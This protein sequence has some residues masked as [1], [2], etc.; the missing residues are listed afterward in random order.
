MSH[1]VARPA[2]AVP[3]A[4]RTAL[5]IVVGLVG[6]GY[7]AVLASHM[8][9]TTPPT[10]GFD[11]ELLLEAGRRVAVGNSPYDPALIGGAV[12]QA[13]SLFYSYPPPVAQLL[14]L[15]SGVPSA[16]VLVAWA[17]AAT[18]AF[19]A[20]GVAVA[21]RIGVAAPSR[22]ALPI[23]ATAPFV[24]PYAVAMLFGNA[25]V[26]FPALY[27]LLLIAVLRPS[28]PGAVTG[29][30]ALAVAAIAKLHPASLGLWFLVHGRPERRI[31][32]VAAVVAIAIVAASLVIGGLDPWRDYLAVVRAGMNADV[33]DPRNAGPTAQVALLL[34]V[35]AG[36]VRLIQVGVS[37]AALVVTAGAARLVRDP[38]E[39]LGWAA[40]ASLFTLPVTWYHYP[41][42]L[43]PFAVA[44]VLRADA[45]ATAIPVRDRRQV[46]ALVLVAAI[47]GVVAIA[48]TPLI[49]VSVALVLAAVRISRPRAVMASTA[50]P[51][52]A[53]VAA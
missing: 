11:L 1:A 16:A 51:P 34:N 21:R 10:A 17:I 7:L 43:M 49:W 35:D 50:A 40:A 42:V 39:S 31:A 29:G 24:F 12:V 22:V 14:S 6:W 13:E 41:V 23:V 2:V 48:V 47:V 33:I 18:A 26:W 3:A 20:V 15:I 19:A 44:A 4:A 28:A 53:R 27:G 5:W 8:L 32:A 45:P 52:A 46:G 38:V 9:A 36:L 37:I 30:A 25:D